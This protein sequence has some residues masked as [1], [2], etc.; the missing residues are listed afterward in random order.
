MEVAA[1]IVPLTAD[2]VVSMGIDGNVS[3]SI[4]L[5]E[6]GMVLVVGTN[7]SVTVEHELEV[8]ALEPKDCGPAVAVEW[9]VAEEVFVVV[10]VM[11]PEVEF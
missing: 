2:A 1:L 10:H 3:E 11:S 8:I 4:S 9:L 6:A 7:W 5:V